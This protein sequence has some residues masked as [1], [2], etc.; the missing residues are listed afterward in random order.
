[1]VVKHFFHRATWTLSYLVYDPKKRVGIVIDPVRDFDAKNGRTSFRACEEIGDAIEAAGLRIPYVLDTHAHADH[2]SGM[3]FFKERFAAK[4]VIGSGI[5]EVQKTFREIFNLGEDFAVDGSQFDHLMTEGAELDV[6]SFGVEALHTP[7]HTPACVTYRVG[8]ALF[9]GDT[10][11]APDSGTAR[12]D[13]P[14]GSAE[15]LFDSIQ[16]LYRLPGETRVFLCHD[17]QPGERPVCFETTVA[18]E[19]DTNV[20]LGRETNKDDYIAARKRRDATLEVPNLILPSIQVNIRAGEFPAPEA[21]GVSYLR[22]PLNA[23]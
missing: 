10:L 16:R 23:L 4:T 8:N 22:L 17:Y 21:N 9:V 6:E 18:E 20:A 14:A 19:R 3:P 7:G 11:F 5:T 15:T 12:C 1:M 13:F 2:L